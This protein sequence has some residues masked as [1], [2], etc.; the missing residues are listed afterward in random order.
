LAARQFD[1][2]IVIA[3]G[4]PAGSAT[5][6]ACAQRGLRVVLAERGRF[7]RDRPGEAL[8]PGMVPLL[9]Q[10]GVADRLEGVVGARYRGVWIHWAGACRF[11]RFG[12]DE[13]GPW[14]GLQVNRIAFDTLLLDKARELGVQVRQPC[15]V[16][17]FDRLDDEAAMVMT[18][19]GTVKCRIFIDAT[20]AAR[21]LS[22]KLKLGTRA[23]SPPLA[24]RY[25]YAHG[26]WPQRDDAPALEADA[27]GWTWTARVRPGIYQWVRLDLDGSPRP[28]TRPPEALRALA[29]LGP[30]RGADVTWRLSEQPAG[31]GWFLTGDAA[32]MLDPTSSH[33]VLKALMSGM[34][35]AHLAA[36][37]LHGAAPGSAATAAYRRWFGDWFAADAKQLGLFYRQL[38]FE[39]F[40][41]RQLAARPRT[42][43]LAR[44]R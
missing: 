43:H 12:E 4:G 18:A 5:A 34:M 1:A 23:Y 38:G 35:A 14:E 31:P 3:G 36:G 22:R 13:A 21:W 10:L 32:A 39:R 37:M 28:D 8:H 16:L 40:G 41:R 17:G 9:A 27:S 44:T 15:P 26:D 20:G 25:G 2:D 19:S 7:E 6:I 24:A 42:P 30:A 29:P 33:G 11:E